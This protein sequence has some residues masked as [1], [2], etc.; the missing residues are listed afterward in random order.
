[1]LAE[2]VPTPPGTPSRSSAL[3]AK[4]ISLQALLAVAENH[5]TA[6]VNSHELAVVDDALRPLARAVRDGRRAAVADACT[7]LAAGARV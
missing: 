1:M 5:D 7:A 6:A 2:R 4:A 3:L